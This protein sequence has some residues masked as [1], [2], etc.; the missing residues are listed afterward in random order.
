MLAKLRCPDNFCQ[1]ERSN[2]LEG[3][4]ALFKFTHLRS[5]VE[6]E[7]L[8]HDSQPVKAYITSCF[9]SHLPRSK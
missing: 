3:P 6:C 9:G 2:D 5:H 7:V 8:A 4:L 1:L